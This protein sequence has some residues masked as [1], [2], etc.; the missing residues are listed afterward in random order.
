MASGAALIRNGYQPDE[1]IGRRVEDFVPPDRVEV[2]RPHYV[3]GLAGIRHEFVNEAQDGVTYAI[4][5]VPLPG[6]TGRRL[7]DDG[8]TEAVGTPQ[9]DPRETP[10]RSVGRVSSPHKEKEGTFL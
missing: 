6:P 7:G 2:V 5:V 1:L 9:A 8:A 4:E 3:E 10:W